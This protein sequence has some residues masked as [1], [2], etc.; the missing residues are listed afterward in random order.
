MLFAWFLS[1]QSI[2]LSLTD[3]LDG[4]QQ[5]EQSVLDLL[6]LVLDVH[7]DQ[8]G[9]GELDGDGLDQ[10]ADLGDLPHAVVGSFLE[11][12]HLVRED[13][14]RLEVLQVLPEGLELEHVELVLVV[15]AHRGLVLVVPVAAQEGIHRQLLDLLRLHSQLDPLVDLS[16]YHSI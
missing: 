10:P 5:L 8:L 6:A 3:L 7:L 11:L 15:L 12:D 1:E 14:V 4:L 13:G 16:F 9:L 2:K